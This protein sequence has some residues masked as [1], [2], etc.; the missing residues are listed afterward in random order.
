LSLPIVITFSK[1]DYLVT[2]CQSTMLSDSM[3]RT[4]WRSQY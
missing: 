3:W 2:K 1:C 4:C